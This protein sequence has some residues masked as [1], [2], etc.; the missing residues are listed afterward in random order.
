[1]PL[2]TKYKLYEDTVELAKELFR[3]GNAQ[4][5]GNLSFEEIIKEIFEGLKKINEEEE[6]SK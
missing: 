6:Y 5:L 4:K 3:G 2:E 1:M